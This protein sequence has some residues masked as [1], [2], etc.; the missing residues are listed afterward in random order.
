MRGENSYSA[1]SSN[2]EDICTFIPRETLT[3][4]QQETCTRIFIAALILIEKGR[5]SKY[6]IQSTK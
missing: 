4:S 1:L 6:P 3:C 2:A 5:K